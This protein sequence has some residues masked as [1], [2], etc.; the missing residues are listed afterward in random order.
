MGV[1]KYNLGWPKLTILMNRV[2]TFAID[3]DGTCVTHSYPNL[4]KEIGA[5]P[6]LKRLAAR[7]HKLILWTMRCDKQQELILDDGYKIHGGDYLTQA[8][9]WFKFHDIP[10]YGIQRNPTQ[11]TWTTSPKCYA[12]YFID[13]AAL[14]SP[15]KFD[16]E[17]SD[18]PFLDW[19][20][21]EIELIKL[22]YI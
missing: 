14:F 15:L 7:G 3:F 19:E 16:F 20:K 11:D 4:G 22:G 1:F 21:V 8:I 13:D 9:E 18:R 6:I 17:L 5:A 2:S 12:E 10:L